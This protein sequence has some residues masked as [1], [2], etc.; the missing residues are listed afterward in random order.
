MAGFPLLSSFVMVMY[1]T[2]LFARL[3]RLNPDG[4]VASTAFVVNSRFVLDTRYVGR[5][6]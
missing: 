2:G 1:H 6:K 5:Q 3:C 4:L